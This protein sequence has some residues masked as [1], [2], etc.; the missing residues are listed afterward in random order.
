MLKHNKLLLCFPGSCCFAHWT[1]RIHHRYIHTLSQYRSVVLNQMGLEILGDWDRVKVIFL[2]HWFY[3]FSV[4]FGGLGRVQTPCFLL[5]PT[6]YIWS[7]WV[8][9]SSPGPLVCH[10]LLPPIWSP[11]HPIFDYTIVINISMI[12]I[13]QEQ[14]TVTNPILF[15]WW[16][17]K[18]MGWF[19]TSE[20]LWPL[21][22]GFGPKTR[23][24]RLVT[25]CCEPFT[26]WEHYM[27]LSVIG[28][29]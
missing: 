10:A 5:W 6:P 1:L 11:T 17:L 24:A 20:A 7:G 27:Q 18:G 25:V 16:L 29:V 21:S 3:I 2:L 19:K 4:Q 9:Q 15:W 13:C 8:G 23:Q 26:A 14:W 28:A 22:S 12:W